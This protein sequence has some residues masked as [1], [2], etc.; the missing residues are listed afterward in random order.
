MIDQQLADVADGAYAGGVVAVYAQRI[1]LQGQCRVPRRW[2]RSRRDQLA[3]LCQHAV[4]I[5]HGAGFASRQQ[6]SVVAVAAV[7]EGFEEEF[8][9]QGLCLPRCASASA[10]ACSISGSGLA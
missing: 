9:T 2:S 10:V 5:V 3:H 7:C 6:A 8:Q 1:D 4:A